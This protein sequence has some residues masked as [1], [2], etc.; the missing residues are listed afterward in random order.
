MLDHG[1]N[2]TINSD[3]PAY[4]NSKYLTEVLVEAQVRSSLTSAELVRIQ[5]NA[6]DAAWISPAERRPY[7]DRLDAFAKAWGVTA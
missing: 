7:L 3:D 5:R 2:V 6:F 1:L 4:M